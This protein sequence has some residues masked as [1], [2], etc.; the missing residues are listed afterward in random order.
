[1]WL[2]LDLFEVGSEEILV[3][4]DEVVGGVGEMVGGRVNGL[5]Y[6]CVRDKGVS[7]GGGKDIAERAD[8]VGC[9]GVIRECCGSFG[10]VSVY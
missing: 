5:G 4:G 1:M 9:I 3:D 6:D 8:C 2:L 10:L 7:D